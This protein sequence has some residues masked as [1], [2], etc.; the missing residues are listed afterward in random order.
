RH[1][2]FWGIHRSGQPMIGVSKSPVDSIELGRILQS[3]GFR[4]AVMLDSGASTS[5]VYQGESLVG[6]IP[7]PVPHV[8]VLFPALSSLL[9]TEK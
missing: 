8:V 7:R 9:E 4:D 6:Y 1:R 2:A 5:L 3:L